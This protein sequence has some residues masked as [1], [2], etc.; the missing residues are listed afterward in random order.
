M[1]VNKTLLSPALYDT[2]MSLKAEILKEL[3]C[4]L[5]GTVKLVNTNRTVSVQ[6]GISQKLFDG[7][8]VPY[9][10]LLD[11]PVLTPQGSG[12]AFAAPIKVGD[13]CLVFFSDRC[14]DTWFQNG[15]TQPQAPFDGRL[16][17]LSDGFAFV[18]P[19]SITNALTL[20]LLAT[21]G[22]I[23]NATSKVAIDSITGLI[24]FSTANGAVSL[25]L[26]LTT[27][28]NALSAMTTASVASG[29]TQALI[30]PLA[31]QL[32]LLLK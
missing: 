25:K 24:A 2:L 9:P 15:G 22:G 8:T 17:D 11:V 26:I 3:R 32:A 21:E 23:S 16:H 27:L 12:I 20:C 14:F 18:G 4:A 29:A 31:A 1:E 5:P 13:E 10:L 19:N 30:A 28:L 6:I 7:S